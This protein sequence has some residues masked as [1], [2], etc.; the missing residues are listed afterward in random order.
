MT[1]DKSMVKSEQP[2]RLFSSRRQPPLLVMMTA[3]IKVRDKD[4]DNSNEN[5]N[6]NKENNG[7]NGMD[8]ENAIKD[9]NGNNDDDSGD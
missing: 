4:N 1:E 2:L 8:N 5:N 3:G 9:E 7:Y 6:H